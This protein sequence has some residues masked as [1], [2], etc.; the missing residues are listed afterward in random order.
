MRAAIVGLLFSSMAACTPTQRVAAGAGI[1][2]VGA[3]TTYGALT[4]LLPSC[5]RRG[6][7]YRGC[8][9]DS[10]A[11]SPDVVAPLAFG[12]LSAVV[13]GGLIM[14]TG[15][16]PSAPPPAVARD[17]APPPVKP[18]TLDASEAV[19]MA[20][21]RLLVTGI[22][23]DSKRQRLQRLDDTQSSFHLQGRRAELTNLRVR[24]AADQTWRSIDAC[25]Q[26]EERWRLL[27][28]GNV[29]SCSR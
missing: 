25:Y 16:R 14:A 22:D 17:L 19:A 8:G 6:D 21:A 26:Y 18:D 5:R 27:S 12:G 9:D 24:T 23:G 1:A 4:S 28:L 15:V 13:L 2:G 20:V 11:M 29:T 10:K 3:A 7:P